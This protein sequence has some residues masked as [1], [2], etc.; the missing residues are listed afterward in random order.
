MTHGKSVAKRNGLIDDHSRK[1]TIPSAQRQADSEA[2]TPSQPVDSE[3]DSL[4]WVLL[5][6][7]GIGMLIPWNVTL[8][9]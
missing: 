5:L 9:A 8:N 7:M 3:Q 4:L 1:P 2:G 6:L